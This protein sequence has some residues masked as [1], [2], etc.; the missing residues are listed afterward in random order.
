MSS[1]TKDTPIEAFVKPRGII[2]KQ[3][4]S[5]S[6][7][8][9][10]EYTPKDKIIYEVFAPQNIPR[11]QDMSYTVVNVDTVS[12]KLAND[13]TPVAATVQYVFEDHH[14]ILPNMP[15]WEE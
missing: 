11:K 13:Y 9:P 12:Q 15:N 4:S 6:G 1:V 3:V 5:L 14:S 7:L 10:S 8:L 2:T